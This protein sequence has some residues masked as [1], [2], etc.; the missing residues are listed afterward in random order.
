MLL[1]LTSDWIAIR[2]LDAPSLSESIKWGA[3]LL[4]FCTLNGTQE[5][6]IAGFED[7]KA[8]A[9]NSFMASIIEI[10][11]ICL[12]AYWAGVNGALIGSG[13]SYIFLMCINHRSINKHF[14]NKVRKNVDVIHKNDANIIWEFGLPAALCNILVIGAL[15]ISR[16]YL[17]RE[18]NFGEIAIYNVADQIKTFI[19]F[20]PSSLSVIILPILTN[21]KHSEKHASSYFKILNYNIMI[22]IV[23]SFAICMLVCL[24]ASKILSLWGEGFDDPMPLIILGVSAVFSAF[25]TVV[26]QAIASQGKMWAGFICNLIWAIL[27]FTLSRYFIKVGM[28]ASGLALAILLAYVLHSLYQYIYLRYFLLRD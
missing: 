23:V 17:V 19:L 3:I 4:F 2:Q 12:L 13:I 6:A 11:A 18:T 8:L 24:F 28:G 22:N 21:I 27:V 1:F 10:A 16:T 15:W 7:F 14:G 20:I 5:G 25:A 26:G 9:I